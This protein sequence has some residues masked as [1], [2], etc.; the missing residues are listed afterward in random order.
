MEWLSAYDALPTTEFTD[1]KGNSRDYSWQNDIPLNG[2]KKT[3]KVNWIRYQ[4]KNNQGYHLEHKYSHGD[5]N[6][7]YNMHLVTLLVFYFHQIFEL[8]DGIYQA[9]RLALNPLYVK[10]LEQPLGS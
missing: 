5:K 9:C 10:T 7:S 4:F 6:L 2:N 8:T 3:I 1:A